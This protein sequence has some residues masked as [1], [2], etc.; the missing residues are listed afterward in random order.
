MCSLDVEYGAVSI[1]SLHLE[2]L[3]TSRAYHAV[4]RDSVQ[5]IHAGPAPLFRV[6]PCDIPELRAAAG[7]LAEAMA[8]IQANF[9]E[10]LS[11][12]TF[13]SGTRQTPTVPSLLH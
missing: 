7:T 3:D 10:H 2:V 6:T 4:F 9:R 1:A 5:V 12:A 8:P 11:L 13:F